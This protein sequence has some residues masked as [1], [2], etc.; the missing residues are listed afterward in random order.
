MAKLQYGFDVLVQAA[1]QKFY[2][3]IPH[4]TFTL[5]QNFAIN[6]AHYTNNATAIAAPKTTEMNHKRRK[7]K[8]KHFNFNA[9]WMASMCVPTTFKT[10]QNEANDDGTV[11]LINDHCLSN[12]IYNNLDIISQSIL[13]V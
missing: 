8:K 1:H 10:A 11:V 4:T 6:I 7:K 2:F 12:G 3:L 9:H 13:T 5:R